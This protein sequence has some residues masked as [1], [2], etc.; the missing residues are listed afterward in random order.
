MK[1]FFKFLLVALCVVPNMAAARGVVSRAARVTNTPTSGYTY[2]YM[3][4]YMNN[5]MRATLNPGDANAQSTSPINAVVKTSPMPTMA[6]TNTSSRRVVARSGRA[7]TSAARAATSGGAGMMARAGTFGATMPAPTTTRVGSSRRV[8]PR[9]SI[10]RSSRLINSNAATSTI[11]STSGGYVSSG[12]CLADYM[13]CMN[14]YCMRSDTPYN[15][16]FCSAKL[17]QIESTYQPQIDSLIK[18]VLRA[19]DTTTWTDAEMSAYWYDKMGQYVGV[20]S[21]E[22]LDNALNI[23]WPDADLRMQ[24]Q[25]AYNAGHEYCVNHLLNCSYAAQNMRDVYRS[26]IAK[27]C[28]NY[29]KSLQKLKTA[30]ESALETYSE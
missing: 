11:N 8:S 7:T 6:N 27:D 10:A 22:N 4:P 20:N 29:E 18:Q 28:T 1:G 30:L 15:R 17:S 21:W 13:D 12:R 9:A 16:C 2:N 26:E 23:D 14:S 24:G 19:T 25:N 5:Q 3:Y